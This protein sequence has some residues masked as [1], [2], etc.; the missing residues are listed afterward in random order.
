MTKT[1]SELLA[2][3]GMAA[4]TLKELN[5]KNPIPEWKLKR[6]DESL[7]CRV[8]HQYE[9]L[10]FNA[11]RINYTLLFGRPID[12]TESKRLQ[13]ASKK[14]EQSGVIERIALFDCRRPS[15]FRLTPNA[16]EILNRPNVHVPAALRL[17][18]RESVSILAKTDPCLLQIDRCDSVQES[19]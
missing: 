12:E 5:D 17:A 16:I 1:E 7:Y 19:D 6:L 18:D 10:R 13:R 11:I 9:F 4:E 3:I 15:H 2:R 14:L 8:N